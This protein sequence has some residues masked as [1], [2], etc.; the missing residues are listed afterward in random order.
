MKVV[1][2][3]EQ[4]KFGA[5]EFD[6]GE[7]EIQFGLEFRVGES[8][9]FIDEGLPGFHGLFRDAHEGLRGRDQT[10]AGERA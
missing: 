7:A 5:R 10:S 1:A 8:L 9:D 3:F 6:F 2:R 4:E